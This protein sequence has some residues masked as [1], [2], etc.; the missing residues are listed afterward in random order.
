MGTT[1]FTAFIPIRMVSGLYGAGLASSSSIRDW[2]PHAQVPMTDDKGH[3]TPAWNRYFSAISQRKL[4]GPSYPTLPD[5]AQFVTQ[6]QVDAQLSAAQDQW[7]AANAQALN[8]LIE[9]VRAAGL[10]GA[11]EVPPAVL[12]RQETNPVYIQPDFGDGGGGSGGGD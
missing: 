8:S 6:A 12:A 11:A 4:G 9:V 1:T 7:T 10:T 2:K 3:V 5:V